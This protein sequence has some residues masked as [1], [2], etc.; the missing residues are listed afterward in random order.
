MRTYFK[1]LHTLI[2]AAAL[3]T[4]AGYSMAQP[5]PGTGPSAGPA[6]HGQSMGMGKHDPAKMQ[7]RMTQRLAELKAK[8]KVT[9]AQEAAWTTFTDAVKP[10]PRTTPRASMAASHAELS[11]LPTPERLDRMRVLHAEH[12]AAMTAQ[13]DQRAEA[14]KTF[15]A[16][17]SADQKKV[18]D[19]QY[20]RLGGGRDHHRAGPMGAQHE[21]HQQPG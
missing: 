11:K 15:Y 9:P 8:L 20:N 17:L 13:M 3:S 2:L 4:L 19:D 18:F 10:T 12:M 16:V 14:T 6:T 21:R 7:A 1:P 5:A